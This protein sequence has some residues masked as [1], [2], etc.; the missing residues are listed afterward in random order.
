ME[1]TTLNRIK[2]EI[3][4]FKGL[5]ITNFIGAA[6][7]IAFSVAFAV[8]K[9]MPLLVEGVFEL[10]MIPYLALAVV[11][12]AVAITWITRGAELMDGHDDIVTELEEVSPDD[13][14][15]IIGII[16]QSLAFYRENQP[17]IRRLGI[18]G[19]VVGVFLLLTAVPQIQALIVGEYPLGQMMAIGQVFGLLGTLAVAALGFFSPII[20]SR[21]TVKWDERL[22]VS[23]EVGEKLDRIL[24]E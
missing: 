4:S 1:Q 22:S 16:V 2:F 18:L 11:G 9:L 6:L 14:E 17:K 5:I 10:Q 3:Q 7:T 24:R 15:A 12:L 23:D 21:F 13:D 19:R 8:P 20:I